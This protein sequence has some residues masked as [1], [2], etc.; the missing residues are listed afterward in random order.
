MTTVTINAAV[1]HGLPKSLVS[2]G[3][4]ISASK[5]NNT[6]TLPCHRFTELSTGLQSSLRDSLSA[7]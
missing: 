3:L 2:H 6:A 1:S 7:T 5:T 4:E